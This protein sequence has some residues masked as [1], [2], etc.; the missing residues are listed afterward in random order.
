MTRGKFE[1]LLIFLNYLSITTII[2]F[3]VEKSELSNRFGI[4]S[5]NY[6]NI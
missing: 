1:Y 4:V 3:I 2:H 6:E 5:Y